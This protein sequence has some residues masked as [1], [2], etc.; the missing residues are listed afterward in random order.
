MNTVDMEC[1][2]TCA[3]DAI[4]SLPKGHIILA[5]SVTESV[6]AKVKRQWGKGKG[7]R[8]WCIWEIK[9]GVS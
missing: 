9:Y 5:I 7:N 2:C 3:F 4:L 1:E 8:S 6:I